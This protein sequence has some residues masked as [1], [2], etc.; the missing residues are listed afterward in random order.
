MYIYF[1][2]RINL[3][4]PEK[5]YDQHLLAEHRE[6]KRIPNVIKSG[7]FHLENAPKNYVLGTGHVKFFYDKLWFLYRRYLAL[8]D[9]CKKRGFSVENY[10]SAFE[11]LPAELCKDFEPSEADIV[12]NQSRLDEKWRDNFYRM[13]GEIVKEK[14]DFWK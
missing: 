3:I 1:M 8:Y 6:I 7:K 4:P 13:H 14:I 5:L 2:T 11:D 12:L 10:A 9:E